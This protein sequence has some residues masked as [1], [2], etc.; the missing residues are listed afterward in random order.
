M[1]IFLK[2]FTFFSGNCFVIIRDQ[3]LS[4]SSIRQCKE[5]STRLVFHLNKAYITSLINF[6]HLLKFVLKI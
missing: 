2:Y 3:V 4:I 6:V 1:F 5:F